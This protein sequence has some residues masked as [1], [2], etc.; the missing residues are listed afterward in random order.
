MNPEIIA[1]II[2][3][4]CNDSERVIR[5]ALAGAPRTVAFIINHHPLLLLAP[6]SVKSAIIRLIVDAIEDAARTLLEAIALFRRLA[7]SMGRPTDLRAAAQS[8]ETDVASAT[9]KLTGAMVPTALHGLEPDNWT[10]SATSTYSSG[11]TEQTR[12]AD[13]IA[14]IVR[15]LCRTLEDMA[16]SIETFYSDL[17]W[18]FI[19]VGMAVAGLVIGIVTGPETLGIGAIVGLV[20]AIIGVVQAVISVVMTATAAGDR[21]ASSAD[22]LASNPA[23]EWKTS[24]FAS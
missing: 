17:A 12:S 19:G 14:S 13:G 2:I 5:A 24:A 20:I 11:L 8:L 18:A 4:G 15:Q 22:A 1:D 6:A 23:I 10:S 3:Q 7:Q 9:A 16:T 21:N